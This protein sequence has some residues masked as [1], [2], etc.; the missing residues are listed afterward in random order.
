MSEDANTNAPTEKVQITVSAVKQLL[1]E[2]LDRPA[3]AKH[4]GQ[5]VAAMA[6]DVWGH[7][8]LKNLKA[9]KPSNILLVDDRTEVEIAKSSTASP[10]NAPIATTVEDV[11]APEIVEDNNDEAGD[12]AAPATNGWGN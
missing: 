8:A 9:K 12:T 5:S 6:R 10:V 1:K 2:G 11:I 4:F 7:P 3:I